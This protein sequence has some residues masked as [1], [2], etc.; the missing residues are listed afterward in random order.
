MSFDKFAVNIGPGQTWDVLFDW[1]DAEGYVAEQH[2][3]R[4][5][6]P[7]SRT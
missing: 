3:P 4:R 7:T 6:S 2:G 5:A 1:K